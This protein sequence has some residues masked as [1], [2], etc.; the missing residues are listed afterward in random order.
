MDRPQFEEEEKTN[1]VR[2]SLFD[3][4]VKLLRP[5]F[6]CYKECFIFIIMK[7]RAEVSAAA[8]FHLLR[9]SSSSSSSS[10]IPSN[11]GKENG[12]HQIGNGSAGGIDSVSELRGPIN[13]GCT[14]RKLKD[15]R[16]VSRLM[17]LPAPPHTH[18]HTLTHTHTNAC[19]RCF[20]G[21]QFTLALIS[22][23][24]SFSSQSLTTK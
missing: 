10:S 2:Q 21:K 1:Q 8:I 23:S 5:C 9:S 15:N 20:Y 14:S 12:A 18:T 6:R 3:P 19:R 22:F 4:E 13:A 16:A 24:F 7:P 17:A 11:G